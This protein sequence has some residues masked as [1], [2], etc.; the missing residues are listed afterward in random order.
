M[1]YGR[2]LGDDATSARLAV[3]V[4]R[5]TLKRHAGTLAA[6]F[7]ENPRRGVLGKWVSGIRGSRKLISD[8]PSS[9]KLGVECIGCELPVES[10]AR[11]HLS[12]AFKLL[13]REA[14]AT[15]EVERTC[16]HYHEAR[17][18]PQFN[19]HVLELFGACL[20]DFGGEQ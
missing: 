16:Q 3:V 12:R 13:L 14:H 11:M 10:G 17:H 4:P 9:R 1:I 18:N 2:W 6:L 8:M 19:E 5:D 20:F 15:G 7:T